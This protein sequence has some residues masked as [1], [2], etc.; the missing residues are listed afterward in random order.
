TWHNGSLNDDFPS[1]RHAHSAVWTGTV[2]IIWG[3]YPAIQTGSRY[4]PATDSWAATSLLGAP[5]GRSTHT[6]VWT[7]SRMVV[8]G[9]LGGVTELGTGG[10]YDPISD[11]WEPTSQTNA[12]PAR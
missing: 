8:W 5:E 6:A 4:D 1:P 2:M 11:T 7:G 3:G 9:G 12:P 10:R